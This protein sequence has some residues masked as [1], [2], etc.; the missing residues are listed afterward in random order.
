MKSLLVAQGVD[1][2]VVTAQG[3]GKAD[4]VSRCGAM[5]RGRLIACLAQDRRVEI[6]SAG[7]K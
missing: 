5:P 2:R 4:P 6:R 1:S 7:V 3:R